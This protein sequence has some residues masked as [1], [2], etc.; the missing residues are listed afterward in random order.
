MNGS[1][2]GG[3]GILTAGNFGFSSLGNEPGDDFFSV[4]SLD[5]NEAI[6]ARTPGA[7][8]S[9]QRF[10]DFVGLTLA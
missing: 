2:S 8:M 6:F 1:K 4:I 7:A 9:L 10:R 5:F 3:A